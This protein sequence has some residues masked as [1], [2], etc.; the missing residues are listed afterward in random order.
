MR[1]DSHEITRFLLQWSKGDHSAL[2]SLTPLVYSEL[3]RIAASYL[4]GERRSHTL[5]PTALVHEAYLRLVG[6][7]Q[8]EW[9]S[10]GHF[11]AFSSRLMRQVLVDYARKH[12]AAKRDGGVRVLLEDIDP[13]VPAPRTADMIALDSAL[14]EL[15]AMDARKAHAVELRYFAGMRVDEAA[16]AMDLSVATFRRELRLAEAWLHRTLSGR[17]AQE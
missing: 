9:D 11:Y 6:S 17:D 3:H 5:Q 14:T 8:P 13:S 2:E 7:H 12:R 4:D 16:R 1:A 15:A 10:R